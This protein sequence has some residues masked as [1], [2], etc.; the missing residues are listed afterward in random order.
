MT[1]REDPL[2]RY[3][4]P[5]QDSYPSAQK[6]QSSFD[7]TYRHSPAASLQYINQVHQNSDETSKRDVP[8]ESK[9][10]HTVYDLP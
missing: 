2:P 10:Q 6:L 5:R 9:V 8:A 3:S 4:N 1:E 7:D